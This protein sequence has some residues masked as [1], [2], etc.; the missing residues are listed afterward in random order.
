MREQM[1][2]PVAIH[3][4]PRSGTTWIGEIINSSPNTIYKFQPL[5]SYAHKDFLTPS[6]T[7]Q[8]IQEFF[9]RLA[10][11]KD[12]FTNRT[13][14]RSEGKLPTFEK[15]NIT[16]IVYKEVRYH[17]ILSNMMRR[18]DELKLVAI[19]RNP[20][21]VINSWFNAGREFRQDLGWNKLEEWRYAMKKNMNKP[22]EYNG[23]EKW[24][25]LANLILQLK[26]QYPD[27][28]Y[29]MQYSKFLENSV[30][31]TKSLFQFLGLDFTAQTEEFL[32]ESANSHIDDPYSVYRSAQTDDAWKT[33]LPTEIVREI[34]AD[35]KDT[36]LEIFLD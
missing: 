14:E 21:S 1:Y 12:R 33:L 18:S 22:E 3:G 24:K 34:E 29:W 31:E 11:C 2:V 16:H 30:Q 19:I 32:S 20:M 5:F 36:A 27:R 26:Q 25:E 6:S 7:K 8:D 35:I 28:I 9:D 15:Q 17:N 23:Y 13:V 10:E 4:A